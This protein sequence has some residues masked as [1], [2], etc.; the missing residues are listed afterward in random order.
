IMPTSNI[1]MLFQIVFHSLFQKQFLQRLSLQT[2]KNALF[3]DF[4]LYFPSNVIL[5]DSTLHFL[6]N[7]IA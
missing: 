4:S 5:L 6:Y 3:C 1:A 2:V 7:N